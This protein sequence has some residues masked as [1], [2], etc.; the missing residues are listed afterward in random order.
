MGFTPSCLLL[1]CCLGA[2]A[3]ASDSVEFYIPEAPPL[4]FQQNPKGYGIAGDMALAA[5]KEAGLHATIVES[6]WARAQHTVAGGK[7]L[8]ITPL[9]RTPEREQQYTWIAPI[10]LLE[11]AFFSLTPPVSS[12]ALAR[13]R[14]QRIAVGLGTPQEQT[15]LNGGIDPQQIVS[16]KLG[17]SPIN[18][19]QRGRVDAWFTGIPEASYLWPKDGPKLHKSPVLNASDIYLA[20]SQDCDAQ[21]VQRLKRSIEKMHRLGML[22]KIR[23]VYLPDY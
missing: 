11:R 20:C 10:M 21:L 23:Q 22:E 16:I 4:T 3:Q 17:E 15:L 1:L 8:L 12:F 5:I 7:N 13:S 2:L 18:M 9:S 14:Y 6:P 19:L